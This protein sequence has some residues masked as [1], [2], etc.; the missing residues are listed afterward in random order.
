MVARSGRLPLSG[1]YAY[2]LKWDGFRA[3]VST[4]GALRVRSRRGWDM[5]EHVLFLERLPVRAVMDGELVALGDDDKPDFPLLCECVLQRRSTVPL[6]LMLF[7]V[8]SVDGETVVR[9]PYSERRRILE[10]LRVD[11]PGRSTPEAFDDGTLCGRPSASTSSS[12]SSPKPKRSRYVPGLDA[13]SAI[14]SSSAAK[15]WGRG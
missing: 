7:D 8:L 3:I 10:T 2:E 4:E 6:T 11:A 13:P 9:E 14:Y 5:T 15:G 12:A 1:D